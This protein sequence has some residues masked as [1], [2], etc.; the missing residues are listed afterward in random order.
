MKMTMSLALAHKNNMNHFLNN[1]NIEVEKKKN[2]IKPKTKC[3]F[4]II[5]NR[6]RYKRT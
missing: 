4:S 1:T 5:I 6:F 2:N 3:Y